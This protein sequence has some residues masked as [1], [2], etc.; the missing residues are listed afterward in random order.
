MDF[1]SGFIKTLLDFMGSLRFGNKMRLFIAAIAIFPVLTHA[2]IIEDVHYKGLKRHSTET[3]S[4]YLPDIKGQETSEDLLRSIIAKLYA[5]NFFD[6]IQLFQDENVLIVELLERPTIIDIT[7]AGNELIESEQLLSTLNL[8]GVAKNRSFNNSLFDLIRRELR[9][10]YI[11]AG[12]YAVKVETR[13][14]FLSRQR[15]NLNIEIEEGEPARIEKIT[16]VGN[17]RF[18][19]Q[20]LANQFQ[21]SA[22]D[23]KDLFGTSDYQK[24]A[25]EGDFERLRSYYLDRGYARFNLRSS[26]VELSPENT[27]VYVTVNIEEGELYHFSGSSIS[28]YEKVLDE[29]TVNDLN[30]I[31]SGDFFSRRKIL[32]TVDDI[33]VALGNEGYAFAVVN[34]NVQID[35][36]NKSTFV[37]INTIPGERVYVHRVD[38]EDNLVSID[39]VVRRELRQF[40]GALYVPRL[41]DASLLRL[42]RTSF[43]QDVTITPRRIGVNKVVLVVRA[44]DQSTGAFNAQIGFTL[45]GGISYGF[46]LTEMN[47]LGR[48]DNVSFN[49]RQDQAVTQLSLSVTDP[50]FTPEN[51]S[52]SRGVSYSETAA[53]QLNLSSFFADR[54]RA[55]FSFGVPFNEFQ[56]FNY[57]GEVEQIKIACGTGFLECELFE[58]QNRDGALQ[59]AFNIGWSYDSRNRGIFADSGSLHNLNAKLSIPGADIETYRLSQTSNFYFSLGDPHSFFVRLRTGITQNYNGEASPFFDRFYSGGVTSV[60]GYETNT[61]GEQYNVDI[62]GVSGARGGGLLFEGR[63]QFLFAPGVSDEEQSVSVRIGPFLDYGTVFDNFRESSVESIRG[64]YGVA[65]FW[66]SPLGPLTFSV[67]GTFNEQETDSRQSFQFGLGQNF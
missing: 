12:Y 13:V 23:E 41:V 46:T 36:E 10:N 30:Q 2:F 49:A 1:L 19:D 8:Q 3:V 7:F 53:D 42:N 47:W 25:L 58:S 57:G 39:P 5:T 32:R 29:G 43:Y 61:L 24:F 34:Q 38:I 6:D 62:D 37:T 51:I 21:L 63:F 40:E 60:R 44:E 54:T 48:G 9:S 17:K 28:G 67:A 27:A 45:T 50:Y 59:V 56:R 35:D 4:S 14:E 64:S 31:K 22:F 18:S 11:N 26:Q 55:F 65:L 20:V 66:I 15:V 33:R 52:F 16:I